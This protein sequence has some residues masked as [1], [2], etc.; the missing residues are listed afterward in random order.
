MKR[1][2]LLVSALWVM[3]AVP[4]S[5]AASL[6]GDR[7]SV[8]ADRVFL[9]ATLEQTAKSNY[10]VERIQVPNGVVVREY[11]SPAGNVFAVA[12]QG[13]TRPDLREILGAYFPVFLKAVPPKMNFRLL[14]GPVR[15]QANGLVVEMAGHTRWLIGR[16]YLIPMLPAGV[17]AREI[18]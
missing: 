3:L 18:Q 12:W 2:L 5:A 10:S 4:L 14:R 13:P 15:I 17:S 9:K 7:N 8:E 11:V 16:A 6:G 1:A